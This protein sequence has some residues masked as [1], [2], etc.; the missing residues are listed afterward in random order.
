MP[1]WIMIHVRFAL[2][3]AVALFVLATGCCSS[4]TSQVIPLER[5][6]PR[7]R[8]ITSDGRIGRKARIPFF[9]VELAYDPKDG[10]FDVELRNSS[11]NELYLS[12][13]GG[14]RISIARGY[15]L[16]NS[17]GGA[18]D[19]MG[20]DESDGILLGPGGEYRKSY[21]AP[22]DPGL[23]YVVVTVISSLSVQVDGFAREYHHEAPFTLMGERLELA[24]RETS[25]SALGTTPGEMED[26][27]HILEGL[28]VP[29]L[30]VD[31]GPTDVVHN[32]GGCP[33]QKP[34]N[35]LEGVPTA[36]QTREQPAEDEGE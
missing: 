1:R 34:M 22:L 27:S 9:E 24:I 29:P 13:P 31:E 28:A 4:Q 33:A 23:K 36:A 30:M 32:D 15:S 10:L 6:A 2:V 3:C 8:S 11:K 17:D 7:C 5:T 19:V 35:E 16:G 14:L 12:S 18:I 21:R 26:V 25:P 20:K